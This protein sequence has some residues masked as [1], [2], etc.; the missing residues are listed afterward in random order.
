MLA[1]IR[2]ELY[3][4][5]WSRTVLLAGICIVAVY[6]AQS[7]IHYRWHDTMAWDSVTRFPYA[8]GAAYEGLLL[9]LVLPACF[10][11]EREQGTEALL[12]S[13]KYGPNKGVA[14][15][16]LAA[17]IYVTVVV[18]GCWILNIVVNISFAG[19]GGWE[20]PIQ[21][22]QNYEKSPYALSVW[23]YVGIQVAT[24]WIGCMV[25]ALFTIYLSVVCKSSMTVLFIAGIV[26]ALPFF[27]HNLS[28]LSIP[29]AIKNAGMMEILRVQNLYNRSRFVWR[30]EW[31]M[32]LPLAGFYSYT[33][34]L[35][36][37]CAVGAY[38]KG[39]RREVDSL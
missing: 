31:S 2:M 38:R 32:S 29:W 34:L 35:G 24:N 16:M 9:L 27:V 10:I 23:Q 18:I 28:E 33:V 17:A 6:L 39:S 12:L 7:F 22:L 19:W 25:L 1:L 30:G 21:E 15:K 36:L 5:T 8:A 3:K 13:A 14:A 4:L 20:L 11:R 26:F 37:L